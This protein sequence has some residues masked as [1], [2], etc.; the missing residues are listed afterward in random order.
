MAQ[1]GILAKILPGASIV[2][3]GPLIHL[4]GNLKPDPIRRLARGREPRRAA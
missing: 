1:T 4:E 3:L 2:A